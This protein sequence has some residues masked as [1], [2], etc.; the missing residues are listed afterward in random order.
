MAEPSDMASF[1]ENLRRERELRGVA[2]R[3]I[4]EATKIS[5]R[6]LQALEQDRVDVLPGGIFPRSFVRQYA[7]H[8][9]LDPDRMVTEFDHVYGPEPVVPKTASSSRKRSDARPLLVVV[10]LLLLAGVGFLA[11]KT[12]RP[13]ARGANAEPS[14]AL[15]PPTSF[16]PDR[17]YPPPTPTPNALPTAGDVR[18]LALTL[19]ATEDCWTAVQ[20]DGAR[21]L[22]R[23]LKTGESVTVNAKKEIVISVGNAGGVTYTLNGRAGVP[24]GREG[25][26]RRN[27][28]I[29]PESMASLLQETPP[30]R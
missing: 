28:V 26:V 27:I 6:F 23:I 15:P 18:G 10:G 8:L 29:T 21:I 1:G 30:P 3:D 22:D 7:K 12:S 25:E 11:W 20:A 4:A 24:L 2:L 17:V 5:V 13:E 16:P 9:G 14:A 19:A